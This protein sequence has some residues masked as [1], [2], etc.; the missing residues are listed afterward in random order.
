MF[1][2]IGLDHVY[3]GLDVGSVGVSP[4]IF[5]NNLSKI[6]NIV[7]QFSIV[8][9]YTSIYLIVNSIRVNYHGKLNISWVT[10][11]VF[12]EVDFKCNNYTAS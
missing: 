5:Y 2:Y 3:R 12:I 1:G 6:R 4:L 7:E 10:S 9:I 11:N 8:R